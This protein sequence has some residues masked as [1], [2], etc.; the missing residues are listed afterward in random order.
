MHQRDISAIEI[1]EAL[2]SGEII[3]DYSGSQ[4]LPSYVILG[5]TNLKRP[6]HIVA[7][8]DYEEEMVWTI[9]AY[10]PN[11]L[12]WEKGYKKRRGR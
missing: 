10:E 11:L 4:P 12:Q 9:T 7:G 2:I 3:E 5:Y 6:I 8:I 1:E